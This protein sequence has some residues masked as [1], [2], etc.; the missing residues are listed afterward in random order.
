MKI[1]FVGAG[2]IG[3]TR[4]LL[5]D[6]LT[7]PEFHDIEV[8]FID[9]NPMNLDMVTQLCQRDI[10]A[11]GL[12]IRIHSTLDRREAFKDAKYVISCVRIGMLE[13]FTKDIEVPLRYGVDQCVGDTL[14]AGGIMY[15]QRDI[16]A[17]EGFCRDI[18]EVAAPG[19][20]LLNY[21]NP[22]AMVTWYCNKYGGVNTVGLCHG[23][24]GGHQL[25]A[26]AL[27]YKPEEV[28]IICA[29]INHMTWY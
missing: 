7:V 28:D 9:I 24:Q 13:A 12:N 11:N 18:R 27:G 14:C 2:S 8:A 20:M 26:R 29:G 25:I 4:R 6:I 21:S 17:F 23:V 16:A 19:C 1:A 3:F 10:E 5:S 22:C 15:A